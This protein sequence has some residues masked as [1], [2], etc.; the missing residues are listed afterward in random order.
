LYLLGLYQHLVIARRV[1]RRTVFELYLESARRNAELSKSFC[2]HW[3]KFVCFQR[4]MFSWAKFEVAGDQ[5]IV[6]NSNSALL[7]R[8]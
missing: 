7:F 3:F 2:W 6:P 5:A 4:A 8:S 1:I